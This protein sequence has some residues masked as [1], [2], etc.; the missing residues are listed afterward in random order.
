M[1]PETLALTDTITKEVEIQLSE[2]LSLTDIAAG[3]AEI[4]LSE[5]LSFTDITDGVKFGERTIPTET[6]SLVDLILVESAPFLSLI[7]I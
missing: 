5:T 3:V 1:P 2:T 4:V 6:L 7:H